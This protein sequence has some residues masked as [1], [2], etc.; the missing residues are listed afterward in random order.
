MLRCALI[1]DIKENHTLRLT[2][3]LLGFD[4]QVVVAVAMNLVRVVAWLWNDTFGG[5]RRA[6][7]HVTRLAPRP[8]SRKTLLC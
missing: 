8:M 6:L 1:D 3:K 4:Q 2:I 5:R 7:G